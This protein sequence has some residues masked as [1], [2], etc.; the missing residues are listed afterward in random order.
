[1]DDEYKQKLRERLEE[2][3]KERM[4]LFERVIVNKAQ[5]K[6][7]ERISHLLKQGGIG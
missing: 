6:A 1:M 2:K 4:F 7:D 3:E 5:R